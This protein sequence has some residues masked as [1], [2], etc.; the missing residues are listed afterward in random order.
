MPH[1]TPAGPVEACAHVYPGAA[2]HAV[3]AVA[4]KPDHEPAAH[5]THMPLTRYDPARHAYTLLTENMHEK[6]ELSHFTDTVSVE[7]SPGLV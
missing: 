2:V 7:L 3:H 5:C 6:K 4:P 1:T